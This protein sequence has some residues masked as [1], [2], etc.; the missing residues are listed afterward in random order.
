MHEPDM[1]WA[2]GVSVNEKGV[3]IWQESLLDLGVEGN[4]KGMW[5]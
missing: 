1:I 4:L 5:L 3:V 2:V